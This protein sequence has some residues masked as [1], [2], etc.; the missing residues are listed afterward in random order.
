VT[1]PDRAADLRRWAARID[2]APSVARRAGG[3][4]TP[5]ATYL[6]GERIDGLREADGRLHVHVVM[7]SDST[8]AEVCRDVH[9]AVADDWPPTNIHVAI[10]DIDVVDGGGPSGRDPTTSIITPS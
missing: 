4:A 10:D 9:A 3:G 8:A 6:P 7:R 1:A 5:V 2:A